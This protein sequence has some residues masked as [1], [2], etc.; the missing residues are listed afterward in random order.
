[1]P[2]QHLVPPVPPRS[3]V[4]EPKDRPHP[5]TFPVELAERCLKLHGVARVGRAVDP[6]LGIGSS[7]VAAARLEHP[8]H[9]VRRSTTRT[10]PSPADASPTRVRC[11]RP[12]SAGRHERHARSPRGAAG[13]SNASADSLE[14]AVD[15]SDVTPTASDIVRPTSASPDAER[16][17]GLP[18]PPARDRAHP[19]A[20]PRVRS[21][22]PRTDGWFV[23]PQAPGTWDGSLDF[24]NG[25]VVSCW[26][27]SRPSWR[28]TRRGPTPRALVRLTN[29][30]ATPARR[31]TPGCS[32]GWPRPSAIVGPRVFAP[33]R[34]GRSGTTRR[35][36]P[37]LGPGADSLARAVAP[38]RIVA[39]ARFWG[40]RP[41]EGRTPRAVEPLGEGAPT[42]PPRP[43]TAPPEPEGWSR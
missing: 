8:V 25:S 38:G 1:M 13:Y 35:P 21:S 17:E 26:R 43:A 40:L 18:V 16:T 28:G 34:P 4:P 33:R 11:R 5:A 41:R 15:I 14:S 29:I 19:R 22:P 6:F 32:G 9:G 36:L 27:R 2:R 10:S 30:I 12:L 20:R 7:A 39:A 42:S 24:P 3:A 23:R 31:P 37:R